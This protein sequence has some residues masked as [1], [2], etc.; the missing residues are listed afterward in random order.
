M[1]KRYTKRHIIILIIA[2]LGSAFTL[3]AENI[4]KIL[5]GYGRDSL[6]TF[7]TQKYLI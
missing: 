6:A 1:M 4:L 2:I 7:S 3:S 5:E